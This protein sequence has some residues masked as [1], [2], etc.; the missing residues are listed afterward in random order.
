MDEIE[1]RF[2]FYNRIKFPNCPTKSWASG[3]AFKDNAKLL[4]QRFQCDMKEIKERKIKEE[5]E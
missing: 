2:Y 3:S 1:Y 4:E 5:Q